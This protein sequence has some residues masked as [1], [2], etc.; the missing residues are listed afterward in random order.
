M[1][2]VSKTGVGIAKTLLFALSIFNFLAGVVAL[3]GFLIIREWLVIGV[4]LV[5]MYLMPKV[6]AFVI[7]PHLGLAALAMTAMKRGRRILGIAL[8]LASS[9][10]NNAVI[11]IWIL[12]S[13]SVFLTKQVAI[14]PFLWAYAVA[15]V[16]FGTMA[17]QEDDNP[18]TSIFLLL[19]QTTS[20]AFGVLR[21]VR[22]ERSDWLIAAL[23]F[24]LVA[25]GVNAVL[26]R[27]GWQEALENVL[28]AESEP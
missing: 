4:G 7:L 1:S 22:E 15:V 20:V 6:Y 17:F 23:I 21:F 12:I 24:V 25:T 13:F 11:A 14:V 2:F 28:D 3:V 9:L 16:P 8:I 27:A 18:A 5:M 19:I 26:L 10:Y